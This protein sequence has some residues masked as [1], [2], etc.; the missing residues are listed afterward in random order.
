[1]K[2][3]FEFACWE[4]APLIGMSFSGGGAAIHE[5]T[6]KLAAKIL[7][8]ASDE[9]MEPLR[10]GMGLDRSTF[11]EGVFCWKGCIYYV[12]CHAIWPR[13]AMTIGHFELP[14]R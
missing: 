12:E 9:E 14:S 7:A 6:A 5:K 3:M 4:I 8:D 10:V 2:K 13:R 11:D 1:M